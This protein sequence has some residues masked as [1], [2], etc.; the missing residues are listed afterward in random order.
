MILL[1]ASALL[2]AMGQCDLIGQNRLGNN[3]HSHLRFRNG[4]SMGN[5][6][7]Q[8]ARWIVEQNQ[9]VATKKIPFFK[10]VNSNK[11]QKT[12]N[13]NTR[14]QKFRRHTYRQHMV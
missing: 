10:I 9:N 8:I 4:N 13:Q 2:L 1:I 14:R 6:E 5:Y 7:Q 3:V 12:T 11:R